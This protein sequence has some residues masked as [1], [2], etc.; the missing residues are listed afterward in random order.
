MSNGSISSNC[1]VV[2][3][4]IHSSVSIP[5]QV[6]GQLSVGEQFEIILPNGETVVIR[7]TKCPE[8]E[9]A[10]KPA[11]II[12]PRIVLASPFYKKVNSS[13][14]GVYDEE[15]NDLNDPE[16]RDNVFD[17][18]GNDLNDP[19]DRDNVFD[20]EGNDVFDAEGN[21]VYEQVYDTDRNLTY[22][23]QKQIS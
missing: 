16:D 6:T 19:E 5:N 3:T 17:A 15:G 20:A 12:L 2:T 4:G 23:Q 10:S 8:P 22:M 21:A 9:P 7:K 18:E 11:E 14:Y 1:I 13:S